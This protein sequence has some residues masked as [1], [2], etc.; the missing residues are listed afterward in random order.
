[1]SRD[2]PRI[3]ERQLRALDPS[4]ASVKTFP[5]EALKGLATITR[6]NQYEQLRGGSIRVPPAAEHDPRQWRRGAPPSRDKTLGGGGWGSKGK[7]AER[8]S[9]SSKFTAAG[10]GGWVVVALVVAGVVFGNRR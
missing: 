9:S 8:L 7:G 3:A 2:P 1:M 4:P 5:S 6:R 10:I